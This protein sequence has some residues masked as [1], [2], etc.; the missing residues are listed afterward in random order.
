MW[1][2]AFDVKR[3]EFTLRFAPRPRILFVLG[4]LSLTL[5]LVSQ[6]MFPSLASLITW[7]RT[8]VAIWQAL[9]AGAVGSAIITAPALLVPRTSVP[10]TFTPIL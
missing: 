10:Y 4:V 3:R 8:D 9:T 6:L 2:F 7:L 1:S 5:V